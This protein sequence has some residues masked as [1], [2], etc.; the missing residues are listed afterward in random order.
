MTQSLLGHL[1]YSFTERPEPLATE[2][3]AYILNKSPAV[4]KGLLEAVLADTD[5]KPFQ[6][7]F[8]RAE[9]AIESGSIPDVT[10]KDETGTKRVFIEN[11]FWADLT[12]AQ[13]VEYLCALPSDSPS[14]LIF[15]VPAARVRDVWQQ[16]ADRCLE[17][18][19]P[20]EDVT[21]SAPLVCARIQDSERF[22]IVTSWRRVLDVSRG[23]AHDA[24]DTSA[25]EDIGQ[26]RGLA[27]RQDTEAFFQ[28]EGDESSPENDDEYRKII[29]AIIWKIAERDRASRDGLTWGSNPKYWL[30]HYLQVDGFGI[31]LGI[32]R[33]LQG[34]AGMT[35]LSCRLRGSKWGGLHGQHWPN[36]ERLFSSDGARARKRALYVPVHLDTSLPRREV[37]DDAIG[38][39]FSIMDRL[40]DEFGGPSPAEQD[41][42]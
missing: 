19:M 3:L 11:K 37:V 40:Q 29:K 7:S 27:A 34:K 17:N 4:V 21:G 14:A 31:G 28:L 39:I 42:V 38:Q 15:I 30:G 23:A 13:P 33:H 5:V 16:L 36:V 8:I 6:P 41:A 9:T 25:H 20:L 24:R 32:I 2:A 12:P 35:P 10:I 26:L 1:V 22:L 18:E